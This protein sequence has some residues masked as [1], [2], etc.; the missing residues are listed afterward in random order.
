M[1]INAKAATLFCALGSHV[2]ATAR[3]APLEQSGEEREL[4]RQGGIGGPRPGRPAC[5]AG[6]EIC[7]NFEGATG[8]TCE[9]MSFFLADPGLYSP[10]TT[11]D[12]S[13]ANLGSN[14]PGNS[15]IGL[16]YDFL[17]DPGS[18]NYVFVARVAAPGCRAATRRCLLD[19]ARGGPSR[20]KFDPPYCSE[21]PCSA[22]PT[23]P[24]PTSPPGPTPTPPPTPRPTRRPTRSCPSGDDI[25]FN[26]EGLAG[27]PCETMSFYLTPA[28]STAS[29]SYSLAGDGS[30]I[31]QHIGI[32]LV[33]NRVI[34]QPNA[35]NY[36]FVAKVDVPGCKTAVKTCL[37]DCVPG[38]RGRGANDPPYCEYA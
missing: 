4:R 9:T 2:F 26:Y 31:P 17:N 18:L 19:C 36:I 20:S 11:Y 14:I 15:G 23:P 24:G 33:T 3:S 7:F 38:G 8:V 29:Y 27:G 21:I 28:V 32:G 22:G 12:H 30:D 1:K 10:A 13:L 37:L 5:P 6:N 35:G 25:V 16:T 34:N